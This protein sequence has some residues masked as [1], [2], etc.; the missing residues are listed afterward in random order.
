MWGD[1]LGPSG[2]PG[3]TG[4]ARSKHIDVRFHFYCDLLRIGKIDVEY[5]K[6]A[7]QHADIFTKALL[8]DHFQYHRDRLLNVRKGNVLNSWQVVFQAGKCLRRLPEQLGARCVIPRADIY[9]HV[10]S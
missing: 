7:D 4:S 10:F 9:F 3:G 5:V 6:S 8:V 2:E 1:Y